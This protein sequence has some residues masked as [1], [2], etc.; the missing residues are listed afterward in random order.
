M[1]WTAKDAFRHTHK[2]DNP[3]AKRQWSHVANSM[4]ERG[5]DEATAIKAASSVVAKRKGGLHQAFKRG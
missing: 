4:L 5:E 2:A 3:T 1:P